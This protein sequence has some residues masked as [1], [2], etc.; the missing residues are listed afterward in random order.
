MF[1]NVVYV[2][3]EKTM[4]AESN[5][6]PA[7]ALP[8]SGC[9]YRVYSWSSGHDMMLA[10][11]FQIQECLKTQSGEENSSSGRFNP[12]GHLQQSGCLGRYPP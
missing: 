1:A 12:V 7:P 2:A 5:R 9:E 6:L 10:K 8:T 4:A 3:P 11:S